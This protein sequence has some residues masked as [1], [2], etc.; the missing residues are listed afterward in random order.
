VEN[1]GEDYN[2]I[3]ALLAEKD[4]DDKSRYPDW[5]IIVKWIINNK[6]EFSFETR[7]TIR[8]LWKSKNPN[9]N[10]AIQECAKR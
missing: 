2:N 4:E 6:A 8:Q 3:V 1:E 7:T 9:G 10:G 5:P